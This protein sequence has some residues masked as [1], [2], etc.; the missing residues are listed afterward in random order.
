LE[1]GAREGGEGMERVKKG[2][3]EGICLLYFI[4]VYEDRTLKP[5]RSFYAGRKGMGE[6]DGGNETNQDSL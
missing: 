2:E 4:F 5:V 6:N 1:D 3:G